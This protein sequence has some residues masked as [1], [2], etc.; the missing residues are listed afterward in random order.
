M[1]IDKSLQAGS[2]SMLLLRLL[3][4]GDRYGY[5]MIEELEN[6]TPGKKA[7]MGTVHRRSQPGYEGRGGPCRILLG[8]KNL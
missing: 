1:A 6:R 3:E 2:T 7:G 4:E 5:Q 8:W